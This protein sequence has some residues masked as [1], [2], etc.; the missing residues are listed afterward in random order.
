M[1][2]AR[3]ICLIFVFLNSCSGYQLSKRVNPFAKY[4]IESVSIPMFYNYSTIGGLASI[5]TQSFTELFTSFKRLDIHTGGG[6]DADAILIG[7]ISSPQLIRETLQRGSQQ[8]A[9][10]KVPT[11]ARERLNFNIPTETRYS[12]SLKVMMIKL[13]PR[14]SSNEAITGKVVTKDNKLYQVVF[15]QVFPISEGVELIVSDRDN[16]DSHNVNFT[17]NQ[18]LINHSIKRAAQSITTAFEETI[19]YAF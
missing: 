1:R 6:Y 5:F 17:N 7:T 18:G 3:L 12:L 14:L 19:L 8:R 9:K 10:S 2:I 15:E 13:L 11:L 16:Y 4:G